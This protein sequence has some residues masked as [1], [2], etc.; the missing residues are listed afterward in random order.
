MKNKSLKEFRLSNNTLEDKGGNKI[1]EA[2]LANKRSPIK[3]LH[4]SDNKMSAE[5]ADKFAELIKE[6]S[7]S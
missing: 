6:D 3:S 5:I 7:G 4:L 2:L 1:A